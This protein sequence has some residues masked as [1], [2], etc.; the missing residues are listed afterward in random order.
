M[1]HILLPRQ[2]STVVTQAPCLTTTV[3]ETSMEPEEELIIDCRLCKTEH[4]LA[5]RVRVYQAECGLVCLDFNCLSF[6]ASK[7]SGISFE[8]PQKAPEP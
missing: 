1:T 8:T 7:L 5:F 2:F 3:F 4:C 6:W